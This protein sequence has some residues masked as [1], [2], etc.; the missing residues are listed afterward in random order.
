MQLARAMGAVRGGL[1]AIE[2]CWLGWELPPLDVAFR[3]MPIR[4]DD[5]SAWCPRC[6]GSIGNGEVTELGCGGCRG[7]SSAID[8]SVRIGEYGAD[9]ATRIL[10]IK[11][12][13]WHSMAL[14]LGRCLGQQVKLALTQEWIPDVLVAVPM[15]W[16][17]RWHRGID[18][19]DEIARGV[20]DVLSATVR[21][22]LRQRM[23]GT[24]VGRSPTE[25]RRAT[26]RFAMR[27]Q[28]PR[29]LKAIRAA[30]S[31][32]IVDDVRTTG[33][34][35][36]HVAKVL[37]QAGVRRIVALTI[38]VAPDPDRRAMRHPGMGTASG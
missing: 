35:L 17:R 14:A 16:L 5:V 4:L 11:H 29:S 9:L 10:Q 34:T 20:A 31:V 21:Q 36:E 38:A 1:G 12:F 25:R 7:S 13:R 8:A 24:Q 27:P 37:R 30:R 23:G 19:A 32:G 33:A 22:P 3:E 28:L 18:H 2:E 15:P 26:G 6:G